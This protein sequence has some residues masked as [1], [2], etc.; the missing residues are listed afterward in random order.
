MLPGRFDRGFFPRKRLGARCQKDLCA[1]G[2]GVHACAPSTSLDGLAERFYPS[3][4]TAASPR[5][6]PDLAGACR[7]AGQAASKSGHYCIWFNQIKY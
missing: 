5:L 2:K 1:L 3:R 7:E 6:Q 4:L